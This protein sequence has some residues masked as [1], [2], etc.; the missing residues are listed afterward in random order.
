MKTPKLNQILA[1]SSILLILVY[2][3][4]RESNNPFDAACPKE[5]FTPSNFKAEQE[6][7]TVKLSWVQ[8]NSNISGFVINRNEND[9]TMTEVTKVDKTG[10][11]LGCLC[12]R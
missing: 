12:R 9:G 10:L 7:T 4:K 11:S 1:L 3:T 2:C 6:G 8:E 5:I